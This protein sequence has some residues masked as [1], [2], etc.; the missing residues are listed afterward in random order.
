MHLGLFLIEHQFIPVK[1]VNNIL[2]NTLL[3]FV[4]VDFPFHIL[5]GSLQMSDG[6]LESGD[7]VLMGGGLSVWL[8]GQSVNGV[9]ELADS[10]GEFLVFVEGVLFELWELEEQFGV[11]ELEL[12]FVWHQF[13]VFAF[14]LSYLHQKSPA[15]IL[16]HLSLMPGHF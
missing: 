13:R 16:Q 6:G 8:M 2:T 15:L 9:L 10:V 7:L 4:L 12:V 14:L 11:R 5:N 1:L 3:L